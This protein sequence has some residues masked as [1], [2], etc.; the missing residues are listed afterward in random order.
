MEKLHKCQMQV[1]VL[2]GLAV[3][4]TSAVHSHTRLRHGETIL[5]GQKQ[6]QN[7]QVELCAAFLSKLVSVYAGLVPNLRHVRPHAAAVMLLNLVCNLY[8]ACIEGHML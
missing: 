5:Q 7:S 3:G 2:L 4:L 6:Q 1:A 8:G